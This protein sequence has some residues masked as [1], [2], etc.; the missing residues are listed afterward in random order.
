MTEEEEV[1]AHVSE[2]NLNLVL[3]EMRLNHR[4]LAHLLASC[5]HKVQRLSFHPVGRQTTG[6]SFGHIWPPYERYFFTPFL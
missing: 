3:D 2:L 5:Y 4:V 6:H 1:E